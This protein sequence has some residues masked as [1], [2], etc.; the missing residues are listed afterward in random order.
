MADCLCNLFIPRSTENRVI[1]RPAGKTFVT[2]LASAYSQTYDG[3]NLGGHLSEDEFS[4]IM[5]SVNATITAYWP[6]S[7][8]LVCGY[9]FAPF[10]LGLSL[11]LPNLCIA[12]GKVALIN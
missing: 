6:C 2:G 11:L 8:S 4:V 9:L 5:M 3:F 12:D 7:C 1:V 10:T